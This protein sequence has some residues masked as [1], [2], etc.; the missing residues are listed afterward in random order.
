MDTIERARIRE[1]N[2]AFEDELAAKQDPFC[3]L[4]DNPALSEE[5]RWNMIP[6]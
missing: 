3:P 4:W 6:F 2:N 5:D 1:L